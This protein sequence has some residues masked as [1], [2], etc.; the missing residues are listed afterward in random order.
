MHNEFPR[1]S[2]DAPEF[3]CTGPMGTGSVCAWR[4][5]VRII[6]NHL[7][8]NGCPILLALSVIMGSL[9]SIYYIDFYFV[10]NCK[11]LGMN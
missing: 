2:T 6:F 7:H 8:Y 1:G 4:P 3:K 5:Q 9:Y 10:K 11:L